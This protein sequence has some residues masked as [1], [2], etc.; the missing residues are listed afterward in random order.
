VRPA[1]LFNFRSVIYS[2]VPDPAAGVARVAVEPPL[3]GTV[4][5]AVPLAAAPAATGAPR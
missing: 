5:D 1:L 3:A 2:F 4:V